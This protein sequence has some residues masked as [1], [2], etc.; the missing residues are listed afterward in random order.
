MKVATGKRAAGKQ[1]E[2]P[3]GRD[4]CRYAV[5]ARAGQAPE[6]GIDIAHLRHMVGRQAQ[7]VDG[8]KEDGRH[9]AFKKVHLPG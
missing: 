1:V 5:D 8:L 3:G 7:P 2:E 6:P 4:D 9:A